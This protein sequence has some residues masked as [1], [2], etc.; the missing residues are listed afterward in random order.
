MGVHTYGS[1]DVDFSRGLTD[2]EYAA[3]LHNVEAGRPEAPP[4]GNTS[5]E[6]APLIH[7]GQTF[8]GRQ[9][10]EHFDPTPGAAGFCYVDSDRYDPEGWDINGTMF[11][12]VG[13][14]R[15]D[16]NGF[17][18]EAGGK[19]YD[20]TDGVSYF[21]EALPLDVNAHGSGTFESDGY[22]WGIA[23]RGR[24][25]REVEAAVITEGDPALVG[26]IVWTLGHINFADG[27]VALAVYA[28]E[29]E[30]RSEYVDELLEHLGDVADW[31][32]PEAWAAQITKRQGDTPWHDHF[33]AVHECLTYLDRQEVR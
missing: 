12:D 8:G 15:T 27:T 1:I 20:L 23:V 33:V 11:G 32:F 21:V 28:D 24:E 17:E 5:H 2:D 9:V 19:V 29:R 7:E 16:H 31:D 30:A 3:W 22:H 14:L 10:C 25:V 6:G 13:I 4:C 18:V 26:S